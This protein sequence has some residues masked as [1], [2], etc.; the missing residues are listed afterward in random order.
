MAR[1]IRLF[2]RL[3]YS[4]A[5]D[6]LQHRGDVVRVLLTEVDKLWPTAG[7]GAIP[8]SL[9]ATFSSPSEARAISVETMSCNGSI[10]WPAGQDLER[11]LTQ[12]S[13]RNT[14]RVVE[15]VLKLCGVTV[16][17]RAGIRLIVLEK[18]STGSTGFRNAFIAQVSNAYIRTAKKQLG[19]ILDIGLVLEG[20]SEDGV[21]YRLQVGPTEE[22]N[23][24]ANL[25]TRPNV[26]IDDL[27]EHQLF[28][29]IDLFEHNFS[30]RE[31]TLQKWAV[32]KLDKAVQFVRDCRDVPMGG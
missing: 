15:R 25:T 6:L 20:Q 29:D 24:R 3:D 17:V 23:I 11:V 5:Y 7:S 16:M 28:F 32:T 19:D 10:E 8:D 2:W 18:A 21:S 14:S 26:G 30:F 1:A 27:L 12:D 31:H 13:F 9:V 4:F 22:K